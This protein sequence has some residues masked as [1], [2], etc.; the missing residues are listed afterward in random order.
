MCR[1]LVMESAPPEVSTRRPGQRFTYWTLPSTVLNS[2]I[3][4]SDERVDGRVEYVNLCPGLVVD[5]SGGAESITSACPRVLSLRPGVLSLRPHVLS[6]VS[7][8]SCTV[9]CLPVSLPSCNVSPSSCTVDCL[10]VSLSSCNV[11]PSSCTVD[12]L[13]V[14]VYCR[15]SP[16]LPALVYCLSVLM[17]CRLSPC[18]PAL[19]YWSDLRV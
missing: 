13:P 1:A 11:S 3:L 18:L 5:Y 6:T 8:S 19:V 16:C 4:N 12:F 7:P 15:L 14:L 10:P 2:D 17:Y 9:D